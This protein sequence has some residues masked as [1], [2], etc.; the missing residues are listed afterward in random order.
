MILNPDNDVVELVATAPTSVDDLLG[1]NVTDFVD[2]LHITPGGKVN[3]TF[4]FVTRFTAFNSQVV[5]EQNGYYVPFK[6]DVPAGASKVQMKNAAKIEWVDMDSDK[7]GLVWCGQTKQSLLNT[8]VDIKT[9]NGM[10]LQLDLSQAF[11]E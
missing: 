6:V 3:G 4:K 5:E 8:K 11:I 7:L 10:E 2:N 1:K 9:D